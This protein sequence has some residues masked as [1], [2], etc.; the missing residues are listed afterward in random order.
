MTQAK[1]PIGRRCR[2]T[3]WD[4]VACSALKE[5]HRTECQTLVQAIWS[6]MEVR[7]GDMRQGNESDV[8]LGDLSIC[9]LIVSTNSVYGKNQL[10]FWESYET[11]ISMDLHDMWCEVDLVHLAQDRIQRKWGALTCIIL[12]RCFKYG[13]TGVLKKR[14]T[15][16]QWKGDLESTTY[17]VTT[18]WTR[19]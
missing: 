16:H 9:G 4:V 12:I 8:I 14:I 11:H 10:L 17:L 1:C 5:C 2:R 15:V 19:T 18:F 7:C 3:V 13:T 6:L